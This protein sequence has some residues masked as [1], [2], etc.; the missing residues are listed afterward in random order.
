MT[1]TCLLFATASFF[2]GDVRFRSNG[3]STAASLVIQTSAYSSS[4]KK[5]EELSTH[6][7]KLPP[8]AH[9]FDL[10]P[11]AATDAV[12]FRFSES[13][14]PA[15]FIVSANVYQCVAVGWD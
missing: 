12:A 15:A 6:N 3:N 7:T 14:A 9:R 13:D 10:L 4:Q 11:L 8:S 1:R 5:E 2:L